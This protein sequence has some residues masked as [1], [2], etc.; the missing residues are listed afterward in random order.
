[1]NDELEA[2][3]ASVALVQDSVLGDTGR[4]SSLAVSLAKVA[5][6]VE[7]RINRVVA[8]G[9]R[10]RTRSALVAVLA[11]FPELEPELELLGS[12]RD[13]HLNDDWVDALR[14]LVSVASDSLASVVPSSLARDP[15]DHAE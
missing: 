15:L 5:E 4:S 8:N 13:T 10:W 11:Y 2:L 6:K 14:P 1:V 3:H 9:V 12:G 7:N